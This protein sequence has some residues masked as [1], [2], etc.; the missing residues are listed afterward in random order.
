MSDA[1]AYLILLLVGVGA[2]EQGTL[3]AWGI[4]PVVIA[5]VTLLM[6]PQLL[7]NVLAFGYA[8]FGKGRR[9]ILWLRRM[10]RNTSILFQPRVLVPGVAIGAAGWLAAPVAMILILSELQVD[11]DLLRAATIYASAA[12]LGG[13]TMMPGGG[14]ATEAVLVVL[15][16][17]SGAPLEAAVTATIALRLMFLWLPVGTGIVLLPVA[18]KV[19]RAG[20]GDTDRSAKARQGGGK[21]SA[22]DHGCSESRAP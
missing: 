11:Y 12:L 5:G 7:L 21:R 13:S 17:A 14:G 20:K 4:L 18:M 15:L 16:A 2:Y 6:K 8:R 1:I 3:V 19:A 9:L 10:V 22:I